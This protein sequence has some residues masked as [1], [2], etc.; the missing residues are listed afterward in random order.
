MNQTIEYFKYFNKE[1]LANKMTGFYTLIIP[2]AFM[3]FA[4]YSWINEIPDYYM[5]IVS[6]FWTFIILLS[7]FSGYGIALLINRENGFL[8]V[9]SFISGSKMPIIMGKMF[10]QIL[11]LL[12]VLFIFTITIGF[13]FQLNV[14]L[15]TINVILLAAVISVPLSFLALVIPTLSVRQET[16]APAFML[17]NVLLVYTVT[18]DFQSSVIN[19]IFTIINPAALTYHLSLLI[20]DVVWNASFDINQGIVILIGIVIYIGIG[21]LIINRVGVTSLTQR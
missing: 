20:S 5:S 10:S 9:F 2:I 18:F 15:L 17:V 16:I 4:N 3:L 13:L 7:I 14:F 6:A 21:L 19:T 11:Y 8:K 1:N 12:V